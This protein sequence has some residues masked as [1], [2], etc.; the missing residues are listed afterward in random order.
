MPVII[1]ELHIKVKVVEAYEPTQKRQPLEQADISELKTQL[2]EECT[3]KILE[4]LKD[5]EN[6]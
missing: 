2:I 1:N 6:R 5:K 3:E 4:K